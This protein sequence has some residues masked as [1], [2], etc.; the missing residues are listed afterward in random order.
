MAEPTIE[1]LSPSYVREKRLDLALDPMAKPRANQS[2][3]VTVGYSR[4]LPEGIML[5]LIFE[6]Q[7]P[8]A[9]GYLRREFTRTAPESII[10][11]PREGG[12]HTLI[13]RE[14]AHNRWW[15][16]LVIQVEG[17]LLEA[18]KPV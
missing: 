14:A 11:T 10:F 1:E 17:E 4:T 3:L 13:L 7:A 5:P 6:V 16:S 12:T 9:Q 18:P 15:Q 8:S 2:L